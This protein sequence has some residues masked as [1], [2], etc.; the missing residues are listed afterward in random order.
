M[1]RRR[2]KNFF[3]F[4]L[5]QVAQKWKGPLLLKVCRKPAYEIILTLPWEQRYP[6][7]SAR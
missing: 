4:I 3:E 6:S 1:H 2:L 5:N 7:L